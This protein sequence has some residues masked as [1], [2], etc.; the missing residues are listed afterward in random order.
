MKP[1]MY[2]NLAVISCTLGLLGL[3]VGCLGVSVSFEPDQ[4]EIMSS[5][6]DE[7]PK[8]N[9]TDSSQKITPSTT[10]KAEI[11]IDPTPSKNTTN[12][13]VKNPIPGSL[14]I[15]N[16]TDQPIRLAILTQQSK[17]Q[18]SL[19]SASPRKDQYNSPAHWDFYPQEGSQQGLIL[20]LPEGNLKLEKGDILVAF[21]QDGSR[22]YWGPYIIGQTPLPKWN[23]QTQEWQLEITP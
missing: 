12:E 5:L 9:E 22:N 18:K 20:S 14:R 4:P 2:R 17:N 16:Q 21:A 8:V 19:K 1:Y 11:T 10:S 7:T 23:S 13:P 15:S 6:V 3:V